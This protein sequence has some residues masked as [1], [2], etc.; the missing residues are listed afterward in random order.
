MSQLRTRRR[1]PRGSLLDEPR[2]LTKWREAM[3]GEVGDNQHTEIGDTTVGQQKALACLP[4]PYP[5]Q[6]EPLPIRYR[7]IRL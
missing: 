7:H 6:P 1:N 3:K 2:V 4:V 5:V